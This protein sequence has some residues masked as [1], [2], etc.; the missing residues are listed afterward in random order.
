VAEQRYQ[1]VR[2]V[3]EASEV[4]DADRNDVQIADLPATFPY[5]ENG[6]RTAPSVLT[7]LQCRGRLLSLE[8]R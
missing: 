6:V 8:R 3:I 2:T 7:L 5:R 4:G 1:A